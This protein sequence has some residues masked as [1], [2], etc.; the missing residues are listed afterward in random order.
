MPIVIDTQFLSLTT[1]RGF[2]SPLEPSDV[3]ALRGLDGEVKVFGT[4]LV[5]WEIQDT[6]GTVQR[7]RTKAYYFPSGKVRQFS[8]QIYFQTNSGAEMHITVEGLTFTTA[9]GV[10]LSFPFRIGSNLPL[11]LTLQCLARHVQNRAMVSCGM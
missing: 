11:M 7:I 8:P 5:E 3:L 4:G 9:D 1:A 10:E 2:Q 6:Q